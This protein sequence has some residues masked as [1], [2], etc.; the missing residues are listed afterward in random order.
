M[1]LMINKNWYMNENFKYEKK[2]ENV[3]E[4]IMKRGVW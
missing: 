3:Y 2:L 4:L 1:K